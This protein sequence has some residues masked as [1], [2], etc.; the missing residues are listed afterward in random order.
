MADWCV[1]EYTE[2]HQVRGGFAVNAVLGAAGILYIA[3]RPSPRGFVV[4]GLLEAAG[5]TAIVLYN[6]HIRRFWQDIARPRGEPCQ[7]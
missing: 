3:K 7:G 1:A 6:R 5:L 4:V 2:S